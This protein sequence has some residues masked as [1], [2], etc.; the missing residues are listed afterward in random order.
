VVRSN[1][2]VEPIL[3]AHIVCGIII[4]CKLRVGTL[5]SSAQKKRAASEATE[6][7]LLFI[8]PT[9][10]QT[11]DATNLPHLLFVFPVLLAKPRMIFLFF[12]HQGYNPFHINCKYCGCPL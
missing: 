7:G 5:C 1:A 10:K 8:I 4:D 12:S 9:I 6:K 11:E 3:K 2:N